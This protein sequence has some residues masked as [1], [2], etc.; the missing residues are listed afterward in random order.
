MPLMAFEPAIPATK[1]P[2]TYALDRAAT[3][4]GDEMDTMKKCLW[5]WRRPI[6]ISRVLRFVLQILPADSQRIPNAADDRVRT[7]STQNERSG[8]LTRL[9]RSGIARICLIQTKLTTYNS[10]SCTV[11]QGGGGGLFNKKVLSSN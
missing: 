8:V 1:R 4:I 2:Q 7:K 3:E 10:T 5:T 6:K 11:Y 9:C